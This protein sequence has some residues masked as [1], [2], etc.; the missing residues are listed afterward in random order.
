[1]KKPEP[2][3]SQKI[4]Q[5]RAELL[6]LSTEEIARRHAE[7]KAI[8]QDKAQALAAAVEAGRFYN[9]ADAKP[10]FNFW[11]KAEFWLFDDA[12]A[13]LLEKNPKVVTWEAVNQAVNPKGFFSGAPAKS[14]FLSQYMALRDLALRSEVMTASARLRPSDV[15]AWATHRLGMQLCAPLQTLLSAPEMPDTSASPSMGSPTQQALSAPQPASAFDEESVE[16]TGA[17][18]RARYHLWPSVDSDLRRADR[19]GLAAAAKGSSRGMWREKNALEWARR[20]G[21]LK[22]A[23]PHSGLADFPRRIVRFE[24]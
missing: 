1:L 22:E 12:I 24:G 8:D 19:N 7:L 17:A 10:N 21:K 20:K 18:L 14:R 16:V 3:E 2:L 9:R 15:V 5:R 13:L 23:Q 6:A 4:R 11:L